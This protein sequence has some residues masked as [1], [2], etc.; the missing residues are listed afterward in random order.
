MERRY[1]TGCSWLVN[2]IYILEPRRTPTHAPILST[3]SRL[4]Q[5]KQLDETSKTIPYPLRYTE[6]YQPDL[7]TQS[8]CSSSMFNLRFQRVGA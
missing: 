7:S 5:S 6:V 3:I 2:V 8:V 1:F 4:L